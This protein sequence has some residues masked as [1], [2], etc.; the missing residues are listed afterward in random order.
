MSQNLSLQNRQQLAVDNEDKQTTNS[1]AGATSL[2]SCE[3]GQQEDLMHAGSG[4][5]GG[6]D[7]NYNQGI[8]Q[9]EEGKNPD[10]N[11]M[12]GDE[13]EYPEQDQ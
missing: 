10:E 5:A 13:M 3:G 11:N 6:D 7:V 4:S 9:E 2:G 1:S 12:Y 8:Q